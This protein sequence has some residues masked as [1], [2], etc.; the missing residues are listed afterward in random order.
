M[1]SISPVIL[2]GNGKL[3]THMAHYCELSDAPY[4]WRKDARALDQWNDQ[5]LET[6]LVWILVS[7]KAVET[8]GR[9]IQGLAPDCSLFHASGALKTEGITALHP[10]FTFGPD[11]YDLK[12]YQSFPFTLIDSKWEQE[13]KLAEYF[14]RFFPKN[15]KLEIPEESQA[16]YHALC[17][18]VSNFPQI[19]WSLSGKVL[20][21]K[22]GLENV[23]F[24]PI[25]QQAATNYILAK[26]KSLTGPLVR[27]DQETVERNLSALEKEP[28]LRTIY[29]AVL[30]A[31]SKGS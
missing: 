2:V 8:V 23:V 28:Q 15:K 21:T 5:H 30:Q 24:D 20:N 10:L 14:A 27:G 6:P 17:V 12:T 11:L 9:K 29:Q 25:I 1:K 18:I 7:D 4:L 3:A 31:Y 16:L 22:T 26:E 13:P 19:L